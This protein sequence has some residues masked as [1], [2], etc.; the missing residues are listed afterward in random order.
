MSVRKFT[1]F[2]ST[3]KPSGAEYTVLKELG[4]A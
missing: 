2:Q 4:L 3:L 1:F